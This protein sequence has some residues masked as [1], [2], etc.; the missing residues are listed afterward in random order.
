VDATD[1]LDD[2]D[3]E[4]TAILW[5]NS[6]MGYFDYT[7]LGDTAYL[8]KKITFTV[9]YSYCSAN[10]PVV[11]PVYEY[12]G[13]WE[14]GSSRHFTFPTENDAACATTTFVLKGNNGNLVNGNGSD[15]LLYTTNDPI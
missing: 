8:G 14:L 3:I 2:T 11:S 13:Y 15:I 4:V 10:F 5:M 6:N 9:T 12:Y 7:D 1:N